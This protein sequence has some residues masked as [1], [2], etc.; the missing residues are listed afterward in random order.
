MTQQ[1]LTH[2][3]VLGVASTA[4]E[5]EIKSAY[6]KAARVSHPDRGGDP[7]E[8]RKVTEAFEILGNPTQR[9]AYDRSF[10]VPTRHTSSSAGR[11]TPG[12]SWAGAWAGASGTGAWAGASGTG[13]SGPSFATRSGKESRNLAG[14]PAIYLPDYESLGGAVPLLPRRIAAQP[15]HGAP[16]KRGVFGASAR[17]AR[18]ARTAQLI[19]QQILPA[20]PAA[21]LING[22][23][24]PGNS[25]TIDHV[26][27][28]G[29]RIAVVGSMRVPDG[30]FRWDGSALI[31]GSKAAVPP[32]LIGSAR[33]LQELFPECNVT[34]WVY[35]QSATGNLFE[36]V[37]DYARGTEPDGG[38]H[39]SIANGSRFVREVR[40]FLASGPSPNVVDTQILSRLLG[41][42][43]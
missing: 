8:F 18:E 43:Y 4:T 32:A 38:N 25:T 16:R 2:Y 6:R 10:G 30:A 40:H 39:L 7:A 37:I 22:L 26:V 27:L 41:G 9:L 3:Q 34:A 29:S 23:A 21:R 15:V 33:A 31:H 35:V 5:S 12:A 1:F 36:P 14:E 19:M 20:I 11:P 24:G 42:M 17:L 13:A 28:S